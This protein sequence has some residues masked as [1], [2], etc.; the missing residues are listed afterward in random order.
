M[1]KQGKTVSCWHPIAAGSALE[2]VLEAV[3]TKSRPPIVIEIAQAKGEARRP[4][5]NTKRDEM[6]PFRH[7][8]R[9]ACAFKDFVGGQSWSD[10][11]TH[12][13]KLGVFLG[14]RLVNGSEEYRIYAGFG[15][16]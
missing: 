6:L 5:L 7:Y 9:D 15:G 4:T 1:S 10:Q 3:C 14:V 12:Q 2:T 8:K 16:W 11:A 13:V